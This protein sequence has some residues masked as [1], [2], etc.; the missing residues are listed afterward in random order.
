MWKEL[1]LDTWLFIISIMVN[2]SLPKNFCVAVSKM[3]DVLKIVSRRMF[4]LT[5]LTVAEEKRTP[6]W[7]RMVACAKANSVTVEVCYMD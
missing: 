5:L 7:A 6:L 4:T 2:K 1:P 3:L